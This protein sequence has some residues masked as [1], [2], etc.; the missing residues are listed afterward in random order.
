MSDDPEYTYEIEGERGVLTLKGDWNVHTLGRVEQALASL[1]LGG[2]SS[3]E[4]DLTN[5]GQLDTAG[6]FLI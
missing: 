5:I 6:A 4:T 1:D 2:V 3:L